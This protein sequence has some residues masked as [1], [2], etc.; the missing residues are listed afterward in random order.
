MVAQVVDTC[1]IC[2]TWARHGSDP[3][4]AVRQALRFN[5]SIQCDLMFYTQELDRVVRDYIILHMI[6]ECIR[7]TVAVEVPNKEAATLIDAITHYWIMPFGPPDLMTWDGEGEL[8]SDEA[9]TW[10]DRWNFK[11]HIKPK[12]RKAYIAERHHEILRVQ[13][14]KMSMQA[15]KDALTYLHCDGGFRYILSEAV[16]SKNALLSIG[17]GTPYSALYGRVPKLLPQI[18]DV[19]GVARFDEDETGVPGHDQC[20]D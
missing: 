8:R 4:I 16:F 19:C 20:K 12:G 17:E 3:R 11:L 2:R 15:K 13:L 14:H 9:Q 1:S 6:C 18:D 10:A 5:Q 7:W